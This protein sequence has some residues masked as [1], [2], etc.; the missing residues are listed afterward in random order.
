MLRVGFEVRLTVALE[1]ADH[2]EVE[3]TVTRATQRH[4]GL[5]ENQHVWL[6]HTNDA[7]SPSSIR[8]V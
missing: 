8:A 5:E 6:A 3:V 1:R 4:L 7:R 2:P